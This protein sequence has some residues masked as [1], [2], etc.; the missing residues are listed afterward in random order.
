M[1]TV[2]PSVTIQ[3]GSRFGPYEIT[4]RIG[5]G[6]MGEVW[7]ARDTRLER[8][9]AIKILHAGFAHDPQA[10]ARFEREA[11]TISQLE[12]PHVCRLYDVGGAHDG[13]LS[14][15]PAYLVMELLEGET[16]R[17]RLAASSADRPAL[18]VR[19]ALEY[20]VQLAE[21]LAAAHD[22]GIVHRD[23][24]PENI[25]ITRNGQ[26]KILD[27]GLA[28]P[29]APQPDAETRELAAEAKTAA[30]IVLGTA[31]Y[32]SPEQVR[33]EALDLRSD[34][35]SMGV[36]LYEM[37]AGRRPFSGRSTVETMHAVLSDEPAAID[38]AA[39]HVSPALTSIIGH[40][41]EK[42]P[43]LR[44]QSA[45]DLGFALQSV[46]SHSTAAPA[47]PQASPGIR[48]VGGAVSWAAAGLI[49]GAGVVMLTN[50]P[51]RVGPD[52][53]TIKRLTF[54]SG[55]ERTPALSP[56]GKSFAFVSTAAGNAD[57]YLQ[58]VDGRN[59]INLT[60][61]SAVTD[62][63]PAFSPDGARIAFRS[64]RDGGGLF[65]M[66]ATGE[67]VR[68]LTNF[69]FNASWSADGSR[70]VFSTES[71]AL[72]PRYR[73]G[74]ATLWIVDVMSG[75]TRQLTKMDGV[76]PSWSPHGSRIAY[77]GVVKGS[78]QRD[79]WT[80]DPDAADPDATA[81][82][83]TTDPFVDWNPFWS[84]DGKTLY[85][86]SDRAGSFN[87][88]SVGIEEKTGRT[89]GLP[90]PRTLASS[91]AAHFSAARAGDAVAF[92]SVASRNGIDRYAID[93]AAGVAQPA[94]VFNGSLAIGTFD[95]SPDGTQLVFGGSSGSQ[96]DLFLMN[97]DGSNVRQITDDAAPDRG[98]A[99]ST[100]GSRIFFYSQRG[101]LYNVY[102]I[103][104]DGSALTQLTQNKPGDASAFPRPSPDG[105]R[106]LAANEAGSVFFN[107]QTSRFE[108]FPTP[109]PKH[110]ITDARW[111]PDGRRIVALESPAGNVD[112]TSGIVVY[113]VATRQYQRVGN[114]PAYALAW[115]SN[116]TIVFAARGALT[117]VNID[118]GVRREV[119][120]AAPAST[121]RSIVAAPD[122]RSI[123]IRRTNT[124]GDIWLAT[125][126]S[127]R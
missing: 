78:A 58:R 85:F 38:P 84:A 105:S 68:R 29:G 110:V 12:H 61:D 65:V 69:G 7:K 109:D 22:R 11:R 120:T 54:D 91:F 47:P 56:D 117:V 88:W 35:F 3:A 124:D 67:S 19:K 33:G 34:L 20:S 24:K 55:L 104:P 52:Q 46:A 28:K 50:R 70:I 41:L 76:Q 90:Q 107:L 102:T 51:A 32:M 64:S 53:A 82:A 63:Q 15:S 48:R 96:E 108:P 16:L 60:Q 126:G 106:F 92:A 6:G 123:Y 57:I 45:R 100:D 101:D 114:D 94:A 103:R 36:I 17:A 44:F 21:G 79:I 87:L 23:L 25:F 73:T 39:V 31:G 37:I 49:V 30:G 2:E 74:S 125:A 14:S 62:D 1:A 122:G 95:V 112:S 75:A 27:F 113:S 72:S 40:C 83:A 121:P 43:H 10:R 4:A 93:G 127:G 98:P 116:D 13:S 118:T 97:S 115:L 5:A 71:V 119:K 77:W 18:T 66:G 59:A 81:V 42:D 99:W 80:I 86:G 9:V 111:S 26:V 89:T 8:N